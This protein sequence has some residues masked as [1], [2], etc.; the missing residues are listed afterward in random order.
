MCIRDRYV[1]VGSNKFKICQRKA[2]TEVHIQP[3]LKE[4]DLVLIKDHT[5]KAFQTRLKG[6]FRV[7][8]RSVLTVLGHAFLNHVH[9]LALCI[10]MLV[11]YVIRENLAEV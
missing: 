8:R 11:R 4:G 10:Y 6:N 9:W 1:S 2:T 3:K 7:V 5:A